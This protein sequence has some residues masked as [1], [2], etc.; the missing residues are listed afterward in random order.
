M[1]G[2]PAPALRSGWAEYGICL[3]HFFRK[4]HFLDGGGTDFAL[5]LFLFPDTDCGKQ[6]TD[7]DTGRTQIAD[8]ID[9]QAGIYFIGSGEDVVDLIGSDGIQAAAE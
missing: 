9:F 6:G 3:A 8:L 1:H 7:A 5:L 2:K 4:S